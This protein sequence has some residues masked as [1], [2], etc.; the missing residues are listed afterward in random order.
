MLGYRRTSWLVIW[1]NLL[2]DHT[3]E[4]SVALAPVDE[5]MRF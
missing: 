4:L 5:N 1:L 3:F 2:L